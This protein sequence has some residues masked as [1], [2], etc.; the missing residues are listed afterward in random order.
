M[1][2]YIS[3]PNPE[4]ELIENYVRFCDN[5]LKQERKNGNS[6]L[7]WA[8]DTQVAHGLVL[9]RSYNTVLV[10]KEYS[11]QLKIKFS[12]DGR[13]GFGRIYPFLENGIKDIFKCVPD[14][15]LGISELHVGEPIS[16]KSTVLKADGKL[17]VEFT[18]P[19]C[20]GIEQHI[21]KE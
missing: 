14:V 21:C 18:C 3:G 17:S 11:E 7:P 1:S 15:S 10:T 20:R 6:R 12:Y 19:F 8:S 5:N 13:T 9:T 4:V 16:A 2:K